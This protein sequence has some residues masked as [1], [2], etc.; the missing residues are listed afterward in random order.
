MLVMVAGGNAVVNH[1]PQKVAQGEGGE[2]HSGLQGEVR[3]NTER[4]LQKTEDREP[5]MNANNREYAKIPLRTR[6]AVPSPSRF[7]SRF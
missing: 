5:R 4:L 7:S 3:A 2:F 1:S 6:F